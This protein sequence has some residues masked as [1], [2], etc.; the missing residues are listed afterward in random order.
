MNTHARGEHACFTN[1]G[2]HARG[3]HVCHTDACAHREGKDFVHHMRG[4]FGPFG[5]IWVMPKVDYEHFDEGRMD[6]FARLTFSRDVDEALARYPRAADG[7]LDMLDLRHCCGHYAIVGRLRATE[8]FIDIQRS[9]Q[10]EA[11]AV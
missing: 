3:G 10:A 8:R 4:A 1:S 6:N 5:E 7:S 2:T 9:I 11:I